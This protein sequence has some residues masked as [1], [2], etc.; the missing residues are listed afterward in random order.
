MRPSRPR[1]AR[2]LRRLVLLAALAA[3]SPAAAQTVAWHAFDPL[4]VPSNLTQPVR[5]E[6]SVSGSVT[7]V[8]LELTAGGG[9]VEMRD[10]GT[11]GDRR[12]GDGVFTG[13]VPAATIFG[14]LRADD[15]QRVF[16]GFLTL[17]NGP[18]SVFRGNMFADVHSP[19]VGTFDIVQL[20]GDVQATARLV[21]IH[22]PLYLTDGNV[23]RVAQTFYRHYG[24]S[25]DF[26]NIIATPSRFANRTHTRVRNDVD[27][28]GATRFDSSSQFGSAGRLRGYS[29]FPIPGFYDGAGTGYSHE[30]GHQ[31]ISSLNFGVFAPGVPHWPASSMATGTMGFSI[32]GAGGQGGD[33]RC[34]VVDDSG[35]VRLLPVPLGDPQ[36]F[37]DFDLY[38]MGLLP[39]ESVRPQVVLTGVTS[40]P[41]CTGQIYTGTVARVT[42]DTIVAGAGR[43]VPDSTQSP[44]RFRAA[45]ILVSRDALVSREM[46]WLY[47]W[48]TARA[49][50][51]TPTP[52]HE[53]FSKGTGNPFFVMTG[54][55][56]TIDTLL[57]SDPDFSLTPAQAAL[58][59]SRGATATFR[60]SAMPTRASFDQPVTFA[61]GPVPAPLACSFSP[62]QVTPGS[63]G[64][65]VTLTVTTASATQAA[66]VGL[67]AFLAV[68]A[69]SL[70]RRRLLAGVA[71]GLFV[72]A[73]CGGSKS[74]TTPSNPGPSTGATVYTITVS[75]SSGQLSHS[76]VLTLTVQ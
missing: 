47:S 8:A 17:F 58:T 69:A 20:A 45:T 74:P 27:G 22:D 12:A 52:I 36:A 1:G 39:P 64:A 66:G 53:G 23:R 32:G 44:K 46:M 9:F 65:D 41:Q 29:L 63:S 57:S 56:A 51:E 2:A 37:N 61:C 54:G 62:P 19:D 15:V 75:A 3:S 59:V 6:A 43:R 38:L 60:I 70:R 71:A 42:V 10:D 14:A 34:N 35:I 7:R 72:A 55:R 21:N 26:L 50:L 13:S 76:T 48:L 16:V 30:T 11:G 49:E 73:S 33:F 18:T 24:D 67:V 5:L 25:Y 28:I 40:P 31:W 4:V 68:T